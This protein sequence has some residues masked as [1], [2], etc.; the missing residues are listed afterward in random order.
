MAKVNILILKV[1]VSNLMTLASRYSLIFLSLFFFFWLFQTYRKIERTI[2]RTAIYLLPSFPNGEHL[3][4]L[5]YLYIYPMSHLFPWNNWNLQVRCPSPTRNVHV[6]LLKD[7]DILSQDQ[8][9]KV[10]IDIVSPCNFTYYANTYWI[11]HFFSSV[12]RS[13][14]G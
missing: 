7:R 6:N 13:N 4:L 8:K 10:D 14:P 12:S 5:L 11:K 3:P 9:Q 1:M 2:Q